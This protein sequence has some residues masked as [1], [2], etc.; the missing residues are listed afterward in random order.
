MIKLY[1]FKEHGKGE[2]GWLHSTFHFSFADYY[3]EDRMNFG[4][5][6]VLN[7]DIVEAGGGFDTHPH[8]NMEIVSYVVSG[9]L[10]HRDSMGNE[11]VVKRGGVQYLSAGTGITHSEYNH[12]DKANTFVQI[13]ILPDKLNLAPNYGDLNPEWNLRENKLF[14]MVGPYESSAPIKIHQ[15]VNIYSLYLDKENTINFELKEGRQIYLVNL[16]GISTINGSELNYG[17][18]MEVT[19]ESLEISTKESTHILILEM[20]SE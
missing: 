5:L 17:D 3:N 13:W 19:L 11:K 8:R 15:D 14:Y 4:K 16:E 7:H 10:Y 12:S 1:R 6:R 2:H 18:A 9:E 20:K